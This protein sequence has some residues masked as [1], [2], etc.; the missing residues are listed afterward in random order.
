MTLNEYQV[1]AVSL[2]TYPKENGLVYTGLKLAGEAGE[3]AD[4]LG[5]FYRGDYDELPGEALAYELGDTLW[6]I[7]ACAQELGYTLREIADMNLRKLN[8]RKDRGVL[9]GDGENR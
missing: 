9:Q 6:Y 7:A 1:D 2:A 4:K 5:K 8:S 3:Y